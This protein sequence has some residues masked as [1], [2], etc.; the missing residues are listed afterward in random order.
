MDEV[1]ALTPSYGGISHARLGS[2]GLQWPCPNPEHPGTPILHVGK[3][4]RGLGKFSA[5]EHIPPAELPDDE[6]PYLLTT[7]RMLYHYHGGSFTRRAKALHAHVPEGS[8]EINPEDAARLDVADG[9][10]VHV[11]S[12]RGE[13]WAKAEVTDKVEPGITFM[14]FHFAEAAANLLTNPALDPVAKIPEY[15]ACAVR[16]E[17]AN[18][19]H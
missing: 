13:V 11:A 19:K 7:G 8:V 14:T 1:A 5:V 3:F 12:R 16:L 6:Y 2:H 18:G 17:K 9:E 4:T 10:L 15:K